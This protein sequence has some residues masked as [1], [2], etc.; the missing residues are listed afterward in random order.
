[1][2]IKIKKQ[3]GYDLFSYQ[4]INYV[5]KKKSYIYGYKSQSYNTPKNLKELFDIM[6][7]SF[8]QN[9]IGKDGI[10]MEKNM[11]RKYFHWMGKRKK[12]S[13]TNQKVL[14]TQVINKDQATFH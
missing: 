5:D 7:D 13:I 8:I 9:Y 12:N 6:G 1:M 3:Y 11:D 14:F 10:D 4:Y 2:K